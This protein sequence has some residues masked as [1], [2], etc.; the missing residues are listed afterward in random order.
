MDINDLKKGDVL[1]PKRAR[2]PK[3]VSEIIYKRRRDDEPK[4]VD[5]IRI[6][7]LDQWKGAS[8]NAKQSYVTSLYNNYDL[9]CYTYD[10]NVNEEQ[11][12]DNMA[13]KLY[14]LIG[15]EVYGF[16]IGTNTAGEFVLEIRGDANNAI[17][18]FSKDKLEEV[19][20][21][22]VKLASLLK[23]ENPRHVTV[24]KGKVEKGDTLLFSQCLWQV[25]ELDTKQDNCPQLDEKKTKRLSLSDF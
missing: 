7:P 17:K 13:N 19:K 2:V 1:V 12:A 6:K 16:H 3:V 14:K 25:V 18:A 9:N 8:Y 24:E 4:V 5:Y 22:T 20:P 10:G 11:G 23:G 15:E 21:Y